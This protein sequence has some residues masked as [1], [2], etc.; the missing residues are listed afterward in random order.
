MH[1]IRPTPAVLKTSLSPLILHP[2]FLIGGACAL[3]MS[4]S[5]GLEVVRRRPGSRM[6]PSDEHGSESRAASIISSLQYLVS[7]RAVRM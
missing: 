2:Q 6:R 1:Q 4:V 3:V 5:H 7:G